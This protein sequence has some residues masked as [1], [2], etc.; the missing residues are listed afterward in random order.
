VETLANWLQSNIYLQAISLIVTICGFL[1]FCAVNIR[2]LSIFLFDVFRGGR[3]KAFYKT[4]RA[5]ARR[6]SFDHDDPILVMTSI[7]RYGFSIVVVLLLIILM[8]A[9]GSASINYL[10]N[11]SEK[12]E[13][14]FSSAFGAVFGGVIGILTAWF[15]F[16]PVERFVA[17]LVWVR[18]YA[19]RRKLRQQRVL[20][21]VV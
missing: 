2:S 15:I 18:K 9:F 16:R 20:R 8:S 4:N 19:V 7:C 1:Y 13:M 14:S 21:P 10:M 17:Y 5:I 6:A 11:N 12:I 3:V